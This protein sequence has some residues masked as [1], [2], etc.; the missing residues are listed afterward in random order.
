[1]FVFRPHVKDSGFNPCQPIDAT[2]SIS[3][4]LLRDRLLTEIATKVTFKFPALSYIPL[5]HSV[6]RIYL[7]DRTQSRNLRNPHIP[8]TFCCYRTRRLLCSCLQAAVFC[9]LRRPQL[10][11]SS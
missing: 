4:T 6:D 2:E 11:S 7:P 1:M 9:P 5:L 3:N 10:L 8:D